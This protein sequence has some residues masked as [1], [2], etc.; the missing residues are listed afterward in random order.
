MEVRVKVICLLICTLT[1]MSLNLL[2]GI[3]PISFK[4]CKKKS[5]EKQINWF[6]L[7]SRPSAPLVARTLPSRFAPCTPSPTCRCAPPF[8]CM[9]K[10]KTQWV[11]AIFCFLFT[12]WSSVVTQKADWHTPLPRLTFSLSLTLTLFSYP[13]AAGVCRAALS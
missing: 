12:C 6:C 11:S 10:R 9:R 8:P 7:Y 2:S 3:P 1:G 13:G 4:K 5:V